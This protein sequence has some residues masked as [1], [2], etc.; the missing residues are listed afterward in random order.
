MLSLVTVP[1]ASA[2]RVV[3]GGMTIRFG[4]STGPM[5]A[6]VRRMFMPRALASRSQHRNLAA[7]EIDGGAVQPGGA[8]RHH[9]G[10]QV[11]DVLDSAKARDPGLAADPRADRRFR[12]ARALHLGA[13]APPLA[14]GLDQARMDAVDAHAVL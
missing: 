14:L 4:I 5:R 10:D 3:I 8:R 9:E 6:G 12:L 11:G 7:V 13:D 2:V 1:S